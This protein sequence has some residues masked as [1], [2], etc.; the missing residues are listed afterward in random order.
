VRSVDSPHDPKL[1]FRPEHDEFAFV[2]D[3]RDLF[4]AAL[5]PERYAAPYPRRHHLH[6]QDHERLIK[7]ATEDGGTLWWDPDTPGLRSRTSARL[8]E[9]HRLR[10]TAAASNGGIP[11]DLQGLQDKARRESFCDACL[12]V[13]SASAILAPPYFDFLSTEDPSFRLNLELVRR[14][15]QVAGDQIP[16]AFVQVTA[17]R[18]RNGTLSNS[19]AHYQATGVRRVLL[20][21]RGLDAP[22][23]GRDDLRA[24]LD[25]IDSFT[26][27]GVEVFADC[28][29]PLGPVLVA[30]GADG[31]ST[32]TRFFQTVAGPLLSLGGGGGGQPIGSRAPG[33]WSE[34]PRSESE[35]A[36]DARVSNLQVLRQHMLLA[37]SDP[38]ALIASLRRDGSIY[39]AGWAAE[40]AERRRR[41]A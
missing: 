23:A 5:V 25:A 11:F 7:A 35:T 6:G 12:E 19:A 8:P 10:T 41:A 40:L 28:V 14:A 39:A 29:G 20:K 32:G 37:A 3:H 15:V 22:T 16:T 13:Q 27:R 2:R 33:G 24:Y 21:I 30:G 34:E 31:F 36:A 17:Q 9:T 4:D 18:L 1:I 26:A 38:D